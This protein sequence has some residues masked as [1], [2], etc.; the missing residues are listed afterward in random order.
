MMLPRYRVENKTTGETIADLG[1]EHMAIQMAK[2]MRHTTP[3]EHFI[4]TETRLIFDSE[5]YVE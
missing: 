2:R 5:E 3:K 1:D 4:V